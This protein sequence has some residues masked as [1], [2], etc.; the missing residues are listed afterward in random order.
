MYELSCSVCVRCSSTDQRTP[1]IP[2]QCRDPTTLIVGA[3]LAAIVAVLLVIIIVV[4]VVTCCCCHILKRRE[5]RKDK[6]L[7][8]VDTNHHNNRVERQWSRDQA[9]KLLNQFKEQYDQTEDT[10]LKREL[11]IQQRQLTTDLL[12]SSVKVDG[13][14]E[15]GEEEDIE[16][17]RNDQVLI[18]LKDILKRGKRNSSLKAN[19]LKTITDEVGSEFE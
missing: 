10:G 19:M 5:C 11:I 18:L 17:E 16:K 8:M 13:E 14:E 4:V 9:I 1:T 3:S 15:D 2:E 12:L 6:E 7:E